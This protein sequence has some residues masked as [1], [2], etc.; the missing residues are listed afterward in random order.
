VTAPATTKGGYV[1]TMLAFAFAGIAVWAY[2]A[3]CGVAAVALGLVAWVRRER[4]GWVPL[5]VGVAGLVV[6]LLLTL[7]PETFFS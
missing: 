7:L 4:W 2:P 3:P 5:A 6:G 1:F